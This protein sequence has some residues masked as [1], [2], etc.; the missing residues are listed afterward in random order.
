M[1]YTR[2]WSPISCK[3]SAGQGKFDGEKQA[4]YHCATQPTINT[5]TMAVEDDIL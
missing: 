5:L 4:F 3:S 2:K 1:V